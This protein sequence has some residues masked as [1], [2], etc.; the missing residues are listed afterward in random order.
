MS[1]RAAADPPP[2][3]RVSG[4]VPYNLYT[5]GFLS[6]PIVGYRTTDRGPV[7]RI[8]GDPIAGM[9]SWPKTASPDGRFLVVGAA[10]PAQL[11]SYAIDCAGRLHLRQSASLPDVPVGLEFAPDARTFYVTMGVTGARIQAYRLGGDGVAHRIGAPRPLGLPVDGLGTVAV[12]PNGKSLIVGSYLLHQLL[13][14]DLRADGT[15]GALRQRLATGSGPIF[16]VITPD[17]RHVYIMNETGNSVSGYN[18]LGDGRIVPTG[19]PEQPT[20]LF[21][22]VPAVTPDGRFMYVPNLAST[23]ISVFAINRNGTL[24]ALPNAQAG[25]G[26]LGPM[27]ESASLSPSGKALWTLGQD[28]ATGTCILQRFWVRPNG[29]LRHDKSVYVDTG[30]LV[31]DG[32]IITIAP[33]Y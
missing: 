21:P 14:F 20:G 24:R 11:R 6:T 13:R 16:P 29:T 33:G 10:V 32:K 31:S 1:P 26:A 28:A 19:Q 30:T 3:G 9:G 17:G 18:I 5:H 27:P 15:V 4:D 8:G 23:F 25:T 7:R 12:T 22:H 2:S